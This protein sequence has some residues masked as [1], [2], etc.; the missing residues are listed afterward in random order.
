MIEEQHERAHRGIRLVLLAGFVLG[1]AATLECS[2]AR[3]DVAA[4]S[5]QLERIRIVLAKPLV[6]LDPLPAPDTTAAIATPRRAHRRQE[7]QVQPSTSASLT[8]SYALVASSD[9]TPKRLVSTAPRF[10]EK[11][12]R[13]GSSCCLPDTVR[14][15]TWPNLQIGQQLLAPDKA[16]PHFDPVVVITGPGIEPGRACTLFVAHGQPGD[17]FV[18]RWVNPFPACWGGIKDSTSWK[19]LEAWTP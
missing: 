3:A 13:D 7:L 16:H 14:A 19:P 17:T 5:A 11:R 4:D 15:R 9:P 12:N 1:L 8:P 10:L 6:G 18:A 2:P